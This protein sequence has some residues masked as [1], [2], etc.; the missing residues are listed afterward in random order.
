MY[1]AVTFYFKTTY[2]IK[3][4]DL[5]EK[6]RPAL[7]GVVGKVGERE[8]GR[9]NKKPAIRMMGRPQSVS[10]PHLHSAS[11]KMKVNRV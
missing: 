5:E 8:A 6:A 3:S 4:P 9:L 7:V 11:D 10:T 1:E 2:I